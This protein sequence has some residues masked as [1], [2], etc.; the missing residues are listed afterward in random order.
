MADCPICKKADA[1]GSHT[2]L[3]KTAMQ[4]QT[5]VKTGFKQYMVTTR[6]F[7]TMDHDYKVCDS[8]ETKFNKILPYTIWAIGIIM[9]V[10]A[11]I[12]SKQTDFLIVV[13][14]SAVPLV[15]AYFLNQELLSLNAMLKR[16]AK[17][18]RKAGGVGAFV[19]F[20]EKEYARFV[21]KNKKTGF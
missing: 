14:G 12:T 21:K 7:G 16:K 15:I 8:C 1:Q 13:I 5:R 11:V 10:L 20:T 6:T 19:A 18:E 4:T 17:K 3:V 9:A 2:H